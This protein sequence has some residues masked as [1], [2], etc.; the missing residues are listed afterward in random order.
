MMKCKQTKRVL[1][2]QPT[3]R[4]FGFAVLESSEN[5]VD[6]GVKATKG[7]KRKQTLAKV[8][9]LIGHYKPNVIAMEDCEG[10]DSRRSDRVRSL[11]D[12]IMELA[13]GQKIKVKKLTV[14]KVK[15]AIA[16]SDRVT[17]REIAKILVE[18]FSELSN[19][20][21]GYRKPWMSEDYRMSIFDA[22]AIGLISINSKNRLKSGSRHPS[23]C[24]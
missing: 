13:E 9:D 1:A 16:G 3:S 24:D 14:R 17:K 4:G 5:L 23:F 15:K 8:A 11:L 22:L 19:R 6:W 18:R 7:D 12:E 20:L 10:P 21:P 2:I